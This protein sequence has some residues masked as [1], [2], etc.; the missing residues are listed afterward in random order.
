M[1]PLTFANWLLQ[2]LQNNFIL[3]KESVIDGKAGR[4]GGEGEHLPIK[5]LLY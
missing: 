5:H 4:S 1:K 2:R 3:K